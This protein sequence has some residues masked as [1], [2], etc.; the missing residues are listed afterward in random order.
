MTTRRQFLGATPAVAAAARG[1]AP[2]AA[3]AQAFERRDI[4]LKAKPFPMAQVRLSAGPF[5]DA[6]EANRRV[7]HKL[8]VDRLMHNFLMN[9]GLASQAQPLGG[10]ERPDCELRGH[11]TGHFLSACSLMHAS[12]GDPAL[13]DKAGALVAEM[14]RCQRALGDG[15]LSAFPLEYWD[16]LKARKKVWAPYYTLHKIM[17]GLLDAHQFCGNPQALEVLEGVAGWVDRWTAPIPEAQMQDILN[18]ENGG[19]NEVLYNLSAVTGKPHY[20]EVAHR[21]D[22][23]RIFDP[24]ALRRDEL[25]GLH[26]NTNVPKIIGAARRYELTGDM[27]YHDIADFFWYEVVTAR[28]YATGG[29]SQDEHWRADPRRIAQ[30]LAM[31]QHTNECCVAYNL[32]KLTR[33]LYQWTDDPAYFDYYER[34]LWNHRLGTID[35]ATGATEYFLPLRAGAWKIFNTEYDSFWC[36]TGTGVEEY[37]KLNDSIYFRDES[38][39]FVNLFIASELNAPDLGVRQQTRFPDEDRTTLII[40]RAP[41]AAM[42]IRVRVPAWAVRDGSAK[43]NGKPLDAF[44]SPGSYLTISRIWR[45][46]DRLEL[47]LPMSLRAEP[48]PDDPKLQAMFYGPLLLA[49]ELGG[50]GLNKFQKDQRLTEPILDPPPLRPESL[51]PL[52]NLRFEAGSLRLSPLCRL[53]HQRYAVY[54]RVG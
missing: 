46:G 21:F 25:K 42:A 1:F 5:T 50:E 6:Q 31:N 38:G 34:T 15:Y 8:P 39:I 54:F 27:H 41:A 40:E 36:C 2:Q 16:R 33:H 13:K 44:S 48:T 19:M 37:G 26:A 23:A 47:T 9:A 49:A 35:L 51:E 3:S 20:A 7:L 45:P 28:S 24:L 10:W 32:L 17:A 4:P 14:A 53:W 52:G 43:L 11:F 22:H 12:T 29:T 18:T 30:E